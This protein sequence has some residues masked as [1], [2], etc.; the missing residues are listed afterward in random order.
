M[1]DFRGGNQLQKMMVTK[2]LSSRRKL[3]KVF[4]NIFIEK[5]GDFRLKNMKKTESPKM[6]TKVVYELLIRSYERFM[7]FSGLEI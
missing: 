2:N 7:Y 3:R 5:M 1:V 4:K 6:T